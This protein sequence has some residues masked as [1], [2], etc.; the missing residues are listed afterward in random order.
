MINK[1]I[2]SF[3]ALGALAGVAMLNTQTASAKGV[4]K[5]VYNR[6]LGGAGNSRNVNLTARN[7]IYSKPGIFKSAKMVVSKSKVRSLKNSNKDNNNFRA[8]RIIKTNQGTYYYKVVSF[9]AQ[10]RGWIYGGKSRTG[11][12]GGVT[13]FTTV[14]SASTSSLTPD[15]N[16]NYRIP[17]SLV[18]SSSNTFFFQAPKYTQYKVGRKV[19][20]N[21][22]V[23]TATAGYKDTA[24]TLVRSVQ[25]TRGG[26]LWYQIASYD[27]DI[28]GAWIPGNLISSSDV[29]AGTN[30]SATGSSTTSTSS[31]TTS[32]SAVSSATLQVATAA[33]RTDYFNGNVLNASYS[34][35]SD[36]QA[37]YTQ[38][39]NAAKVDAQ[40][41]RAD[42]IADV[43][44]G[45]ALNKS[46]S[47][48]I[49]VQRA[50]ASM[51]SNLTIARNQ[52]IQD[53]TNGKLSNANYS[54][55]ADLQAAYQ[56]GY[57]SVAATNNVYQLGISFT[58]DGTDQSGAFW[59]ALNQTQKDALVAAAQNDKF[60]QTRTEITSADVQKVLEDANI[61]T[62]TFNGRTIKFANADPVTVTPSSTVTQV[63]VV[64]HYVT[65]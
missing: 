15:G 24:F 46:Y 47:G 3:I 60:P 4:N 39:Y 25:T 62:I 57:D 32:S 33:G 13:P 58:V 64:A 22:K 38:G 28:N 40:K 19:G 26:S 23:I 29:V 8:Y 36:L 63:P 48:D 49:G 11:F 52:G 53:C 12:Y 65:Q 45:M 14:R 27:A 37:A 17:S 43:K 54:L 10:Y 1:K 31:S 44:D 56:A 18:N 35:N 5:V 2:V 34:N 7:A 50:Y 42:A 55:D 6:S 9:D 61:I 59:D 20:T 41:A 51:F 30:S 16:T 21:H